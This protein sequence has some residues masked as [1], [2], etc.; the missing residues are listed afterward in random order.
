[1]EHQR[2]RRH[3]GHAQHAPEQQQV[4]ARGVLLVVRAHQRGDGAGDRRHALRHFMQ[5]RAVELVGHG[6]TGESHR[7]RF[8]AAGQHADGE[9]AAIAERRQIG[10]MVH[11]APQHQR[12]IQRQ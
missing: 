6:R 3:A 9:V 11:Q 2:R 12:R 10:R 4:V 1:M 8:L 5:R 7:Q